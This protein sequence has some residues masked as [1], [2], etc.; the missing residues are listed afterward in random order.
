[1]IAEQ[2]PDLIL[3]DV[4]MPGMDGYQV[5]GRIKSN[6]ATK[7]IPIDHGDGAR[8]SQTRAAAAST[9]APRTFS[10]SRSI[11]PSSACG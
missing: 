5:A 11:A 10:P 8:R 2:P 3:L 9:P 4:M 1:M 7:N 6:A